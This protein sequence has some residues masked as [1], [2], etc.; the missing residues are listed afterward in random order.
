MNYPET[1][2]QCDIV[3]YLQEMKIYCLHI[4]NERKTTPQAM[5]RLIA[6]GLRKGAPDLLVFY[7]T[8]KKDRVK[9]YHAMAVGEQIEPGSIIMGFIEVKAKN[10]KQSDA[11]KRF[12]RRCKA[13]CISYD[14][15][16]SVDEVE[17]LLKNRGLI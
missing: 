11:Q 10:G 17:K 14:L 13:A 6:M 2:I 4:P 1:K 9:I 7:P 12:E 16:Y 8:S 15:V 3:H 5:G